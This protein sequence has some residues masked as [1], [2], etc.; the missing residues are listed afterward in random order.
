[1]SLS[2]NVALKGRFTAMPEIRVTSNG[3]K[4]LYFTIA[5]TKKYNDSLGE[6]KEKVNYIDCV[7]YE[8]NSERITKFFS[9]G[10]QI[11]IGGE[12]ASYTTKDRGENRT[13]M[14]VEV[15]EWEFGEKKK[16]N[17]FSSEKE[18]DFSSKWENKYSNLKDDITPE[19]LPFY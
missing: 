10:D 17:N 15:R 9:K 11:H 13:K 14:V 5:V 18:N 16:E 2:N 7:A 8:P 19:E 1:M 12:I 4:N 6:L 3:K